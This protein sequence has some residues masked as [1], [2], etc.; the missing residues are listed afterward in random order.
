[1]ISKRVAPVAKLTDV[2]NLPPLRDD[3]AENCGRLRFKWLELVDH[4]RSALARSVRRQIKARPNTWGVGLWPDAETDKIA[5]RCAEIIEG[6]V[7]GMTLNLIPEDPF[8]MIDALV[9]GISDLADVEAIM[10]IEDEFRCKLPSDGY[11][12]MTFSQFVA[13][14][15]ATAGTRP[16]RD[17]KAERRGCLL[18]LLKFFG[19]V[20]VFVA[21]GVA[22]KWKMA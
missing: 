13:H 16:P 4:H 7:G 1:M 3:V 12:T 6:Y 9:A 5:E 22:L 19:I 10:D 18:A 21:L 8:W 11:E 2:R 20:A 14:V 15:K 17:I